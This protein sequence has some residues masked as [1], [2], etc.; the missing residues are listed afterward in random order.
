M[1]EKII[2]EMKTNIMLCRLD[3]VHIYLHLHL[4]QLSHS[5]PMR[6]PAELK[7]IKI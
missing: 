4:H 3:R 5:D 1:S 6:S 2:I 7:Q